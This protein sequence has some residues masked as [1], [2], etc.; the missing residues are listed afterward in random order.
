[1]QVEYLWPAGSYIESSGLSFTAEGEGGLLT[2]V[3]VRINANKEL[4]VDELHTQKKKMHVNAFRYQL[5]ETARDLQRIAEDEGAHNR[6]EDDPSKKC[7]LQDWLRTGG[8]LECL[9]SGM[10]D[11]TQVTFTV[12]GLLARIR[13][14]CKAVLE[15]HETMDPERYN[16]DEAFRHTVTEMLETR[17]AAVS[18]LRGYIEDPGALM[19]AMM[20]AT[21]M[22]CHRGYLSFLERT[23]QD[24]KNF[25]G[26]TEGTAPAR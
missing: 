3:P 20:K 5:A 16:D 25:D 18:T 23:P 8:K 24:P 21:L 10:S 12:A 13:R 14:Q 11:G 15:R 17:V 9:L 22:G 7:D 1:V 19:E 2:M 26:S 6:L 4:T